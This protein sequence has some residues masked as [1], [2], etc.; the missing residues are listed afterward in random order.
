MNRESIKIGKFRYLIDDT[1]SC[2][3]YDV[4]DRRLRYD[5]LIIP[6][7][8]EYNGSTYRV[9][10]VMDFNDCKV[11]RV[12]FSEGIEIIKADSFRG[13]YR[14]K[15]VSFP[16]SLKVIGK[17]SFYGCENL[18]I[19]DFKDIKDIDI[20][21]LSFKNTK[22]LDNLLEKA[23]DEF[24][25]LEYQGFIGNNLVAVDKNLE[26]L[27]VMPGTKRVD[28]S[29]CKMN[30]YL[31]RVYISSGV[32]YCLLRKDNEEAL[33]F[34]FESM[35]D[36]VNCYL[37]LN[38]QVNN[39]FIGNKRVVSIDF[40]QDTKI[41]YLSGLW[42]FNNISINLNP[43]LKKLETFPIYTQSMNGRRNLSVVSSIYFPSSLEKIES[44]RGFTFREVGIK[45]STLFKNV[46]Y[47]NF[48]LNNIRCLVL[49]VDSID[50]LSALFNRGSKLINTLKLVL[51]KKFTGEEI[52][53]ILNHF[54]NMSTSIYLILD[55]DF[56]NIEG[57]VDLKRKPTQLYI[58]EAF[59]D[60]FIYHSAY[61]SISSLIG[62]TTDMLP[63][64]KISDT[65]CRLVCAMDN[66]EEKNTYTGVIKVPSKTI[67]GDKIYNVTEIGDFAFSDCPYLEEV[68]VKDGVKVSELA[69]F[70]SPNV[71]ITRI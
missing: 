26:S 41:H 6:S 46:S 49:Y 20:H 68:I 66:N 39:I 19:I 52:N 50:R 13:C 47:N 10:M 23:N 37:D 30:K 9:V 29:S 22:Y 55:E 7:E 65:E 14:L 58:P 27:Y 59:K 1:D 67:I 17:S 56:L 33:D 51:I 53:K 24:S 4:S 12:I 31:K 21:P 32:N 63:Y 48:P 15:Y 64:E 5:E 45:I 43:E 25:S 2:I 34:Y 57:D 70:N 11:E 40:P 69:C 16:K 35:S 71:K 62:Y 8:I 38:V 60:S 54:V 3:C 18:E 36:L 28:L 42:Y 44:L 61:N